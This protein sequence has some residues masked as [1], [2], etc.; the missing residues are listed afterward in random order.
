VH[1]EKNTKTIKKRASAWD[2]DFQNKLA[3]IVQKSGSGT[4]GLN[5][6]A[7]L[8]D[9]TPTSVMSPSPVHKRVA[10]K[11]E[12]QTKGPVNGKGAEKKKFGK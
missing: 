8:G 6:T 5:R 4:E 10:T 3:F 11:K 2:A 12:S 7:P 1:L 9:A